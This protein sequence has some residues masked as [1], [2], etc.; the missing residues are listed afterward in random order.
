LAE[1]GQAQVFVTFFIALIINSSL[2]VGIKWKYALGNYHKLSYIDLN[3]I[4]IH[5]PTTSLFSIPS[6]DII[7]LTCN[8]SITALAVYFT[9]NSFDI[10]KTIPS[11]H[12]ISLESI[13]SLLTHAKKED[14]DDD[15]D[16]VLEF[17]SFEDIDDHITADSHERLVI[18]LNDYDLSSQRR[19]IFDFDLQDSP[20]PYIIV[21]D[22][23]DVKDDNDDDE[24]NDGND[25][26][27]KQT[28][29][30]DYLDSDY[31]L[32]SRFNTPYNVQYIN[33]YGVV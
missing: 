24:S 9:F 1:L 16:D 10:L 27:K 30:Q 12:S 5:Y 6:L 17:T 15:D 29:Q 22:N 31:S 2:L 26:H 28:T 8:L 7:L 23:D 20:D 33:N 25:V 13:R 4:Y 21:D 14:D 11:M 32:S 3:F 18:D 19:D